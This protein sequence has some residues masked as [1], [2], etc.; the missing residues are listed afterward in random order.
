M[1]VAVALGVR[2]RRIESSGRG[3]GA[4]TILLAAGWT[5]LL[6]WIRT[7]LL[8]LLEPMGLRVATF[9]ALVLFLGVPVAFLARALFG[10]LGS[11]EE[12]TTAG[13]GARERPLV[14]ALMGAALV[15]PLVPFVFV[16]AL[17][18]SRTLVATAALEAIAAWLA[19]RHGGPRRAAG[20]AALLVALAAPTAAR[21]PGV[22]HDPKHGLIERRE[23]ASNEYR[24]L[25][26]EDGRYLLGTAHSRR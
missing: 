14:A 2:P 1:A 23:G 19:S 8:F 6:P 4:G 12:G 24:V 22:I 25:D 17:G 5:L 15:A 26:L 18:V 11:G 21:F 20:A 10:I 9:V 7:P 3:S 16:P 13:P